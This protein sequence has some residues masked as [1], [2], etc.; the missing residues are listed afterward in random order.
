MFGIAVEGDT[1]HH[2]ECRFFCHIAT[3]GND[4]L[5]MAGQIAEVEITHGGSYQEAGGILGQQLRHGV[6]SLGVQGGNY[7]RVASRSDDG[8]EHTLQIFA[9]GHQGF[10]VEGEHNVLS[11]HNALLC[12]Y[13]RTGKTCVVVADIVYQYV[14]Y[15]IH[16]GQLCALAVGHCVVADSSRK[17]DVG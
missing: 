17:Q 9:C 13:L 11:I 14:A 2:V 3:V 15:H 16:F 4:T 5:G 10:A 12:K 6:G 8:F 7:R 1:R